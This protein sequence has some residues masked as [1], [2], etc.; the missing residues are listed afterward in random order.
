MKYVL[1][2]LFYTLTF[3]AL[4]FIF[5][6][7]T[8]PFGLIK[9]SLVI[10]LSAALRQ[11]VAVERIS[12]GL[13][14]RITLHSLSMSHSQDPDG[15]LNIH[16]IQAGLKLRHL[17]LGQVTVWLK[18]MD[19]KES[20]KTGEGVLH[21]ETQFRATDLISQSTL[22]AVIKLKARK[23]PLT[24]LISYGMKTYVAS[25]KANVLISPL[26]EQISFKGFLESNTHLTFASQKPTSLSGD[27]DI[28]LSDFQFTSTDPNLLIPE[29][30]F[31][32]ATLKASIQKGTIRFDPRSAFE[33]PDI[34]LGV[35]GMIQL[36]DRLPRSSSDLSIDLEMRGV[37]LDQLG[38][39]VQMATMQQQDSWDGKLTLDLK[40]PLL[41]P[42]IS[43]R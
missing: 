1:R 18:M 10:P 24:D 14:P 15:S 32:A 38:V 39:I 5:L 6:V 36:A 21:L 37:I 34:A 9:E 11:P 25:P 43:S 26:L 19:H 27:M 30:N 7:I 3:G 33:A 22:P 4:F 23:F 12:V 28:R 13:P 17:F 35:K 41:A 40:G 2:T 29:Q 20:R 42:Q 8:F 31:K 16:R